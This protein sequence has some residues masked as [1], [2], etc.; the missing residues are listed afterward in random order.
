MAPTIHCVR[1]AQGFHNLNVANHSMHDPLL[2]PLGEEQCRLLQKNFPYHDKIDAV[3]A[4]PIKR[5]IYTALLGF[6]DTINKKNL[7][8]IAL[9]E[10]QETSDLP[11]DTPSPPEQVAKEFAGQPVDLSLVKPGYDSKRGKW[12]PTSKAIEIRAREARQWFMHRPEKEIVVVT[13]GG[14]L[15]YFTEDWNDNHRFA[16]TG[17]ANT[18]YRS[19]TFSTSDPEQAHLIET[20]ESRE[21][22]KAE[23]KPLDKEEYVNLERT[24]SKERKERQ[25]KTQQ[26]QKI[27]AKV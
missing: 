21:R 27:Q 26:T 1:H 3:V 25:A 10:L 9:P 5:T 23:E 7:K 11:C 14:F 20:P 22:R 4:S 12:A 13:H 15:H 6:G 2:T 17:W 16:G 8:V 19:Y 18:E 24:V